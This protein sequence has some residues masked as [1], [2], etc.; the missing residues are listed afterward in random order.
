MCRIRKSTTLRL[1][2]IYLLLNVVD[3]SIL[4]KIV[5]LIL[6]NLLMIV[7]FHLIKKVKKEKRK[8]KERKKERW[9]WYLQEFLE[10][11]NILFNPSP[12]WIFSYQ[13]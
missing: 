12:V 4:N 13:G 5:P 3:K 11:C 1:N 7:P 9:N 8:I 10:L 6:K 2:V